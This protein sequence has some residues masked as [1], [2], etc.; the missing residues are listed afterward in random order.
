MSARPPHTTL[1]FELLLLMLGGWM[2]PVLLPLL[3]AVGVMI[4]M[5]SMYACTYPNHT[6]SA[7]EAH[8]LIASASTC[9]ASNFAPAGVGWTPSLVAQE[10]S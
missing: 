8:T 4:G 9:N 7:C 2:L 10:T 1:L 5:Y 6:Q 3:P